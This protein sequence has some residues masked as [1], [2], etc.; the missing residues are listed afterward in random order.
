MTIDGEHSALAILDTGAPGSVL[1]ASDL[2]THD[3]VKLQHA[4]GQLRSISLGPLSYEKPYACSTKALS[5]N[6]IL[7]GID[8]LRHFNFVFDYPEGLIMMVPRKGL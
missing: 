4:C 2:V 8:F 5:G 7:V 6:E 3:H 1:I